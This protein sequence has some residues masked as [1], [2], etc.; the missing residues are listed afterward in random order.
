MTAKKVVNAARNNNEKKVSTR[1]PP[2]LPNLIERKIY[3]TGQTRGADD[4]EIYQN[5]VLRN[6]TVII[7]ISI[8]SELKK[9]HVNFEQFEN[10][11][12]VLI[13]PK[14]YFEGKHNKF[15]G[16]NNLVLGKNLL[17]FYQ[18]RE[19][20]EDFNPDLHSPPL[21]VANRRGDDLGGQYV[22]RI[23][24]TTAENGVKLIRGYNTTSPKGAGIRLFE[25]ASKTTIEAARQQLEC[26]FWSCMDS[27][28]VVR[29]YGMSD[30]DIM[31][32][33][34]YIYRLTQ[35]NGYWDT[36]N[37]TQ[38]RILDDEGYTIC[39]LCL[40]KISSRGF[41]EKEAQAEGREVHN[42]TITQLNLFHIAELRVGRFE[43]RPYNL[44]WGH[45]HCNTV[46]RDAGI[47]PTLQWMNNV[48]ER[49]KA[50]GHNFLVDEAEAIE[51][52]QSQDTPGD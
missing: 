38:N 50:A 52:P 20:W 16:N 47:I 49:N 44:G 23:P 21:M 51:L 22:A 9:R 13:N 27:L 28:E 18:L 24:G 42:L 46:V 33:R 15:I 37:L 40:R 41:F 25:Y 14:D 31:V 43:H 10:G 19:D 7:P 1:R 36:E 12:V 48:V 34:D 8:F 6:N 29:V 35:A 5:R 2:K 4:D 39:P 11:Y 30:E 3:K 17:I 32:R 45:H 26:L